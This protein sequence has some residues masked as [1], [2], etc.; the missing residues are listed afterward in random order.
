MGTR[1]KL[2]T[3]IVGFFTFSDIII[4]GDRAFLRASGV[5]KATHGVYKQPYYGYYL[6]AEGDGLAEI[7]EYF[8]PFQI[9]SCFFGKQERKG[10]M[11]ADG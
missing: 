11:H 6:R 4:D 5:G 1:F 9:E 7:I 3:S 8:D 10:A 2:S